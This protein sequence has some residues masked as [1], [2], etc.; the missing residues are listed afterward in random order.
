MELIERKTILV[1]ARGWGVR[2]NGDVGQRVQ[3]FSYKI[4]FEDLRYSMMAIVNNRVLYTL[5][6]TNG[7]TNI[8]KIDTFGKNRQRRKRERKKEWR[9]E[10]DRVRERKN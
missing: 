6:G 5:T 9:R 8:L 10:G 7:S 4:S 3:T 2:G 1:I